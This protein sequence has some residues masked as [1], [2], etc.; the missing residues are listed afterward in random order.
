MLAP[1][2]RDGRAGRRSG[3]DGLGGGAARAALPA[4][5]RAPPRG[6]RGTGGAREPGRA[7]LPLFRAQGERRAR[8]H[9]E[10]KE[11][12]PDRTSLGPCP[13]TLT[14]D[15]RPVDE[16]LPAFAGG[17]S[18]MAR[19]VVS[20][21][22]PRTWLA[23]RISSAAEAAARLLPRLRAPEGRSFERMARDAA[24]EASRA[25]GDFSASPPPWPTRSWPRGAASI[26]WCETTRWRFRTRNR[27]RRDRLDHPL[28]RWPRPAG[29]RLR[30]EG[31]LRAAAAG[32][33]RHAMEARM[34][35]GALG[36]APARRR[37]RPLRVRVA[38]GDRLQGCRIVSLA[39]DSGSRGGG[40][41]D[42]R[43]RRRG[44]AGAT[45]PDGVRSATIESP[46]W[47]RPRA[48]C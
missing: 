45:V 35:S 18:R 20:D 38:A 28:R 44:Q 5:P 43:R 15:L 37:G 33:S 47:R 4:L 1:L 13:K 41:A 48:P 34:R 31:A 36:P 32:F 21:P 10:L 19:H 40:R 17:S 16:E 25:D 22:F 29:K 6:G 46:A 42:L 26:H 8:S 23:A 39:A 3:L 11:A 14:W 12:L 27:C 24:E 7:H 30:L 9:A 2:R